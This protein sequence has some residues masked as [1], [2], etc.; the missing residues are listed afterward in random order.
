MYFRDLVM[1]LIRHI[2]ELSSKREKKGKGKKKERKKK[3]N[4]DIL[5]LEVVNV[6]IINRNKS[7]RLLHQLRKLHIK[8]L[9]AIFPTITCVRK[10]Y[11]VNISK[12]YIECF[13]IVKKKTLVKNENKN[14]KRKD[15]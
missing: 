1:I 9:F 10:K 3:E 2:R 4:G 13:Y 11:S 6:Y 8:V 7:K 12:A 15:I 14:K 5:C